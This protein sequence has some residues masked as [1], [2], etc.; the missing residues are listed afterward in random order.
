MTKKRFSIGSVIMTLISIVYVMPIFIVLMNSFKL[1]TTISASPFTF[2]QADSFCGFDN[3]VR[4][5]TYGDYP[6]W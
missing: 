3:Y 2:P 6:F 1:K 4:G 5:M